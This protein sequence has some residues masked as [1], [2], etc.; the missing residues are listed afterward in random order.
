MDDM[1]VLPL[2]TVVTPSFNQ[3]QFIRA[4]IES[5]LSQDYPNLEYIIMDGGS[6]DDT[7]E[8]VRPYLNRLTYISEPDHGQS[9]AI[10]KGFAMAKGSIVAWLNSD[11]IFLPGAISKAVAAL[12][13]H[14]AAAAV[15]GDGFQIDAD[16]NVKQKF[17]YTQHFDRWK[18]T[19]VSD[20]ILQQTVFFR[21][22]A[23]DAVG[24][25]REDLHFVMDWEI[26]I[27]LAQRFDFVYIPEEMGSIREYEAA[28][29]S[30][31]GTRRATEIRNMLAAYWGGRFSPGFLIYGFAAYD[32]AIRASTGRWPSVARL[33]GKLVSRISSKI[34]MAVLQRAM[35]Y[36]QAWR[37]NAWCEPEVRA[38][39]SQGHGAG[40]I[41]GQ[42]PGNVGLEKQH[43]QIFHEGKLLVKDTVMPGPYRIEFVVPPSPTNKCPV[44]TI[45][46]SETFTLEQ[47]GTAPDKR[48][49]T[50]R[51]DEVAWV[52]SNHIASPAP[53]VPE[54]V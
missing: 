13:E 15:Y 22:S 42:F 47:L 3:A 37:R 24:P 39:L 53:P 21:K 30:A 31:G 8:V 38:M 28:K 27:R 12:Q 17:P 34:L 16:G 52:E 29:T 50:M 4:T 49:L 43:I 1:G 5:V 23:L 54:E 20:Y 18:L 48:P 46:A 41:R 14:P 44:L 36:G 26:L 32:R 33:P 19:F 2:V 40:F 35:R 51:L 25:L 11:D 10:N 45:R 6:T 7:A 9:H